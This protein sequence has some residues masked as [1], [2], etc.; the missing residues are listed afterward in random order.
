MILQQWND[1]PL[2]KVAYLLNLPGTRENL[3]I[4]LASDVEEFEYAGSEVD[5]VDYFAAHEVGEHDD[6]GCERYTYHLVLKNNG[7]IALGSSQ[8]I[9]DFQPQVP[10]TLVLLDTHEEHLVT[11]DKRILECPDDVL[12]WVTLKVDYGARLELLEPDNIYAFFDDLIEKT[13][14]QQ[15]L[16][17]TK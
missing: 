6:K 1:Y 2:D 8:F 7:L 4:L 15:S 14:Q 10:G 13:E 12:T 3:G 17:G 11:I 9:K 5:G 16:R